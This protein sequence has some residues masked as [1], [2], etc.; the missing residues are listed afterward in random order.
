M[1]NKKFI[2]PILLFILSLALRISLLSK[3]PYHTDALELAIKSRLTI[4]TLKLHYQHGAGYPFNVVL[5]SISELL[6]SLFGLTDFTAV[7]L[8]SAIFG[9]LAVMMLFLVCKEILSKKTALISSILFSVSPAF[10]SVSTFAINHPASIFF[11]LSSIYF[12]LLFSKKMLDKYLILSG[13]SLSLCASTRLP[14]ILIICPVL[15]IYISTLLKIWNGW[16]GAIT[17]FK[18]HWKFSLSAGLPLIIF[19]MPMI[20]LKGLKSIIETNRNINLGKF[21]WFKPRNIL[22]ALKFS[23][24]TLAPITAM[25]SIPGLS[26]LTRERRW[27][28][29]ILIFWSLPLFYFYAN[30]S[31]LEPRF[32][33]ISLI[34]LI[35]AAAYFIDKLTIYKKLILNFVAYVF[36]LL[37]VFEMLLFILPILNFRHNHSLIVDFAKNI[38]KEIGPKAKV[39]AIDEALFLR[40]FGNIDVI[41]R[42]VSCDEQELKAFLKGIVDKNLQEGRRLFIIETALEV[43]D[44]DKK[45]RKALFRQYKLKLVGEYLN[46]DWHHDNCRLSIFKEKLFEIIPAK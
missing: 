28:S 30:T 13:I 25:L 1:R 40:Y 37:A 41:A 2:I 15:Y 36:L 23:L 20:M 33:I 17:D 19:Y 9:S 35:I 16:H 14:D 18:H 24:R 8:M 11:A 46:E 12:M 7:N 39:I 43:Y 22:M 6:L 27:I 26:L 31:T 10:L 44:D 34:P 21:L 5:G 32:L 42:P 29:I 45:F 4:S 38:A 3:G